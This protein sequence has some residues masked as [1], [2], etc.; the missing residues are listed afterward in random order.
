MLMDTRHFQLDKWQREVSL[1]YRVLF[2]Q[3]SRGLKVAQKLFK[4]PVEALPDGYHF[5]IESN[6]LID[7]SAWPEKVYITQWQGNFSFPFP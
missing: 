4:R 5:E 7:G 1:S 3:S 6:I 2:G